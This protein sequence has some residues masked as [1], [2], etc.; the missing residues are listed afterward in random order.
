MIAP[1]IGRPSS[2]APIAAY[3]ALRPRGRLI[4]GGRSR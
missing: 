1:K 4:R 3:T 2:T